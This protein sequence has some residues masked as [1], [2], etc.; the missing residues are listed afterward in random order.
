MS[1]SLGPGLGPLGASAIRHSWGW[2]LALGILEIILGTLAMA[3]GHDAVIPPAIFGRPG[4]GLNLKENAISFAV[5]A[6]SKR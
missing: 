1:A 6:A 4:S 3:F 5:C 2:F